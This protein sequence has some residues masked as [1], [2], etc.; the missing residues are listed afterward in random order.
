MARARRP[1]RLSGILVSFVAGV[2]PLA[3]RLLSRTWSFRVVNRPGFE[4]YVR[5]RRPV[6]AALWHQMVIPG[7]SFFRDRGVTVLVSR[8]RDGELIA[9]VACRLGF[10]AVRGSS[11]RGGSEALHE[12]IGLLRGGGQAAI[13]VDGPRGPAREPKMGC[14]AAARNAGVPILPIGCRARRAVHA[15]S[16]DRTL[17][18]LP[19]ARIAIAFGEPIRVPD[20]SAEG[21]VERFRER[22]REAIDRAED[23]AALAL[24]G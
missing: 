24:G 5:G 23:A 7:V 20:G 13:T 2:V 19:F 10:R 17:I 16:W 8:S 21:E 3:I 6:V 18:P 9:R 12:L 22:V 1:S 4:E 15:R 11:S 14:V